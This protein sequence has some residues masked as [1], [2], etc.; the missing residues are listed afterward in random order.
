MV[1]VPATLLEY[2]LEV[3]GPGLF[4]GARPSNQDELHRLKRAIAS[5]NS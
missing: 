4:G 1:K 3:D 5:V 2:E